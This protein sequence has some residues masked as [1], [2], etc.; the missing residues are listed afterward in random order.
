L[1]AA[2]LAQPDFNPERIDKALVAAAAVDAGE[3][4][5]RASAPAAIPG[6]IDQAREQAIAASLAR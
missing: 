5:R 4:A 3:V 6:L 1:Q 2:K